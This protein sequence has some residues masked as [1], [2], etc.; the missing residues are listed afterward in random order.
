MMTT[1]GLAFGRYEILGELGQGGFATV[2]RAWDPLLGR[3]VAVKA[4]L[5]HLAANPEIRRR[6]LTEARGIAALRH[7]NIVSFYD[8]GE[9]DGRPFFTME[10]IDG[11]TLAELLS[12]GHGLPLDEVQRIVSG[13]CSAADYFH[14]AGLVHRD[15]KAS[16]VML[17][18]AGGAV[19]MDFG[20]VLALDEAQQTRTGVTMGTPETMAPEQV[21]GQRAG[22]EADIYS[23][24]VLTY[25]LLAGRPPFIGD[26]GYVLHAHAY[27]GP[28]PLENFRLGLPPS[29]YAAVEWALAKDPAA[30]PPSADQF[31][32]ALSGKGGTPG[33]LGRAGP[34]APGAARAPSRRGKL[35][36]VGAIAAGA[37]GVACVVLAMFLLL[38]RSKPTPPKPV[39]AP[40]PLSPLSVPNQLAGTYGIYYT[41]P[42]VLPPPLQAQVCQDQG[43][44]GNPAVEDDLEVTTMEVNSDGTVKVSYNWHA[45]RLDGLI[46]MMPVEA[47]CEQVS[48]SIARSDGSL[49]PGS[50][51]SD[52][53]AQPDQNGD[54]Y[55]KNIPGAWTFKFD[56]G[57]FQHLSAMLMFL[58][59]KVSVAGDSGPLD[60]V[61]HHIQL[62]G[63]PPDSAPAPGVT[64]AEQ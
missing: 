26:T 34:Q 36:V 19:L 54:R 23:L 49:R 16:N 37:G 39:P 8:V 59:V 44:D 45:Q 10:L 20:I 4:L 32:A 15:I 62:Q 41:D 11:P 3:Q 30:R 14:A 56:P 60:T 35:G 18:R 12:A 52:S 50:C 6:F 48:L 38:G 63:L 25:Q 24:G 7:P 40:S 53:G 33:D 22:P 43:S 61:L 17:D 58:T 13:L 5:P 21:R 29:V 57:D 9:A 28:P 27:D 51:T 1:S 55:G 64:G 46:C 42:A 2:Y 47:G 31:M